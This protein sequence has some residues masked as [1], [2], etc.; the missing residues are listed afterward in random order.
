MQHSAAVICFVRSW[1][2]RKPTARQKKV[3][4]TLIDV[5]I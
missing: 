2:R 4:L 3:G 1:A 5:G